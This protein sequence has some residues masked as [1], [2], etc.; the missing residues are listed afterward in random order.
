MER[1]QDLIFALPDLAIYDKQISPKE[2][3]SYD[4]VRWDVNM[5]L[6][7]IQKQCHNELPKI[8]IR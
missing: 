2:A 6:Q 8:Q 7:I 5:W 1:W 3:L 4:K